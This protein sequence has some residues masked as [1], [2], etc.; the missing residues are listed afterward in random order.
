MTA[1]NAPASSS[2]RREEAQ[3]ESSVLVRADGAGCSKA[4]LAHVHSLRQTGVSIGFSVGWAITE[5]ERAAITSIPK[6]VWAPAINA[7]GG[8]RDGA[9]VA[10]VTGLLPPGTLADY[11]AGTRSS[12][13]GNIPTP[14]PSS[15]S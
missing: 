3:W 4:F 7:D 1:C 9:D 2:E 14:A 12:S 10:E 5:R 15:R 6:H 8:L 13:V 11:P